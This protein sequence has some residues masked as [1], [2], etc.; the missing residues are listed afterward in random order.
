VH[1][2][3]DSSLVRLGTTGAGGMISASIELMHGK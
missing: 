2:T 3:G 1:N